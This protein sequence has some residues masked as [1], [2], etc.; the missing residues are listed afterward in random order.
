[1]A[2]DIIRI[3]SRGSALALWQAHWVRDRFHES[4]P[5]SSVEIVII[6]TTGDKILDAP[7]SRIGDK[8]LFTRE[9]ERALLDGAIDLAV[10]SLKD[11]PTQL[12]EGLVL[13]AVTEREDVRDVFLPRPDAAVRTLSGQPAGA[14]IATGSL[15][16]TSQLLHL[17]PDL[18][19]ID[20]RG[21]LNTRYQKLTGSTWG[22]M[23]LA[24]AGVVRLG[25]ADRIGETLDPHVMLPAVGQGALGIEIRAGDRRVREIV[26]CLHHEP[27]AHATTAERALLRALEGG[28]QVPIGTYARIEKGAL[29]MDAMVGSLDGKQVV[30]GSR[31]APPADAD[32]LGRTLADELLT[33]GARAILEAIRHAANNP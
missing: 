30:R 17:R 4:F 20:L 24:R 25:W 8:G 26:R 2:T 29:V 19:I 11:L 28:C 31:H 16:R 1:M 12:P 23:I 7:L 5:A 18:T 22:G 21:N 10:H 13:G 9:I 15:R 33:R 14:V 32:A 27:T 6:K 3:G